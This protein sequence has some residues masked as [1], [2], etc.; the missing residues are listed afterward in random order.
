MS[1][2]NRV[3]E[4]LQKDNITPKDIVEVADRIRERGIEVDP[5]NE[6]TLSHY[7]VKA[8][9]A[10]LKAGLGVNEAAVF[11][12]TDR[13]HIVFREL[14]IPFTPGFRIT[15]DTS[16]DG[17]LIISEITKSAPAKTGNDVDE[18]NHKYLMFSTKL[19]AARRSDG[20]SIDDVA[21]FEGISQD[22]VIR[23]ELGIPAE[24]SQAK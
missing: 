4:G 14:G 22:Q 15:G 11:E 13:L 12:G 2:E 3:G 1:A 17:E 19:G 7:G 9:A 18:I 16:K 10:R 20:L 6:S 24:S 5:K 23:R 8:G 21:R